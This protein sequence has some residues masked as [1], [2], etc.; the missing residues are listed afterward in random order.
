MNYGYTE[1]TCANCVDRYVTD[2]IKAFGH[3]FTEEIVEATADSMGYTKHICKN[4]DFSYISDI[5]M[6]GDNG[7]T[8]ETPSEPDE[9][10]K[11]D[12]GEE[13][14]PSES[15]VPDEG[16]TDEP[17]D[18][19]EPE[20]PDVPGG[21][22]EHTHF[23]VA[24]VMIDEESLT[25]TVEYVCECGDVSEETL[26]VFALDESGN[27]IELT[28]TEDNVYDYSALTGYNEIIV[29]DET[30]EPVYYFELRLEE[31]ETPPQRR[32]GNGRGTC[33]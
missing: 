9:P 6:S 5:V 11:P 23:Y 20:E 14:E 2:Y 8:E 15:E 24:D 22:D 10:E 28:G 27:E 4:C 30:G 16:E 1:H 32:A 19:N 7:Y 12:T 3:E 26:Q 18:P 31:Q 25:F 21:E 13:E 17:T 33:G 29:T